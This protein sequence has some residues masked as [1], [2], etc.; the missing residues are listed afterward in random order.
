[1]VGGEH[2]KASGADGRHRGKGLG[3]GQGLRRVRGAFRD[4]KAEHLSAPAHRA[5]TGMHAPAPNGSGKVPPTGFNTL[6]MRQYK[7]HA[8]VRSHMHACMHACTHARDVYATTRMH[9][10]TC[11][12]KRQ[13]VRTS[14]NI[15]M[16]RSTS[17]P[18]KAV[19]Q[20]SRACMDC[21]RAVV[22]QSK[23]G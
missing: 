14:Q 23:L 4:P 6:A 21:C 20:P 13:S 18:Q 16:H 15:C 17:N 8:C 12:P 19:H 9:Q 11:A 7:S 3:R 2:C 5:S 22:R 10:H 1:V